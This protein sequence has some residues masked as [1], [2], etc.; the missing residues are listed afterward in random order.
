MKQD[1]KK[2]FEWLTKSAEQGNA[3]GQFSLGQ[4]F[5]YGYGVEQESKQAFEW[6]TKAAEQGNEPALK[7]LRNVWIQ[8]PKSIAQSDVEFLK[9]LAEDGCKAALKTL[10]CLHFMGIGVTK[11]VEEGKELIRQGDGV[12][13][14]E[15]AVDAMLDKDSVDLGSFLL[16]D[17]DSRTAA[18]LTRVHGN[19]NLRGLIHISAEAADRL[20]C[21]PLYLNN[22]TSVS[23]EVAESLGT[24]QYL[25]LGLPTLSGKQ[26]LLL[27][28]NYYE[29]PLDNITDRY[30]NDSS[31]VGFR[32]FPDLKDLEAD[33]AKNLVISV[34]HLVLSGLTSVSDEV[35]EILS[36]H[37]GRLLLTGLTSLSEVAASHM[38]YGNMSWLVLG[39]QEFPEAMVT[40]LTPPHFENPLDDTTDRY[41]G[42]APTLSFPRI[43]NL[44]PDA[45]KEFTR[46]YC[47][48]SF[49]GL[50]ALS[51]EVA[52]ILG[53][54]SGL[55]SLPNLEELSDNAAERLSR[56]NARLKLNL[57]NLPDSAATILRDAGHT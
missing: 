47:Y 23:D 44:T 50:T 51:D 20:R 27:T 31:P 57:D 43:T 46:H 40:A 28:N 11:N 45:A 26:S 8:S 16:L 54:H 34:E 41:F 36:K 30:E 55:L 14:L 7:C 22:L 33:V 37:T 10:G 15:V 6:Y 39:F 56:I 13:T 48:L 49:P 52:E 53:Q 29:N 32:S 24:V 1:Y 9:G 38:V 12:I 5:H 17:V 19:L 21:I 25:T 42:D 3:D 35:A 4:C 2:A 18:V